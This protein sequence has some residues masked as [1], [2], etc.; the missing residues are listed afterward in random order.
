MSEEIERLM[1]VRNREMELSD[2]YDKKVREPNR[3]KVLDAMLNHPSGHILA[4]CVFSRADWTVFVLAR[5]QLEPSEYNSEENGEY[6]ALL[7]PAYCRS[8]LRSLGYDD[9]V[10]ILLIDELKRKYQREP[11]SLSS[12]P[13]IIAE[14]EKIR[15]ELTEPKF[16]TF[17]EDSDGDLSWLKIGSEW[18]RERHLIPL[19]T[20][21]DNI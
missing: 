19:N 12:I 2:L 4:E 14:R 16:E 13:R 9:F 10:T 20:Y 21:L 7:A 6:D 8:I 17:F 5:N 11:D 15:K 18:V 1:E 3:K